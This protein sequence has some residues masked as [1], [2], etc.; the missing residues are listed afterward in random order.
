M[1]STLVSASGTFDLGGDTTI[2]RLGYGAMQLTGD[3]VW[4]D[5]A[6][7][8]EAVAVLRRAVELGVTFIDTAD[9]YGPFVSEQLIRKALHPYPRSWSSPPRRG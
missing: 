3:G 9:S 1:T 5:P 4:G 6:D 7:P 2:N 8:E